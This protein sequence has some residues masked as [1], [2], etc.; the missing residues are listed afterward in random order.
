M[1][2]TFDEERFQEVIEKTQEL[3]KKLSQVTEGDES[4]ILARKELRVTKVELKKKL[5]SIYKNIPCWYIKLPRDDYY[6][7]VNKYQIIAVERIDEFEPNPEEGYLVTL[8]KWIGTDLGL[9]EELR[10]LGK[11]KDFPLFDD[12]LP[13]QEPTP[14]EMIERDEFREKICKLME[15]VEEDPEGRFTECCMNPRKYPGLTFQKVALIILRGFLEG[16]PPEY[17]RPNGFNQSNIAIVFNEYDTDAHTF[18]NAFNYFFRKKFL[19]LLKEIISD[20]Y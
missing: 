13:S 2:N 15:Y 18:F 6:E 3:K 8:K 5:E 11:G 1:S 16:L 9:D 7:I 20:L 4:W 17:L 12:V 14:Q 10:K 19:P